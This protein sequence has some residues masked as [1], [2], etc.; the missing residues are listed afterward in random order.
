M[1]L[2]WALALCAASSPSAEP[3]E[4]STSAEAAPAPRV[5]FAPLHSDL[6][7]PFAHV[8]RRTTTPATAPPN[9]LKDP[10]KDVRPRGSGSA[11]VKS[12]A[13]LV[14]PFATRNVQA[15]LQASA[16]KNPFAPKEPATSEAA[17][18][19]VSPTPAPVETPIQRPKRARAATTSTPTPTILPPTQ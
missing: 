5:P 3:V 13:P 9:D 15:E 12:T 16:L 4:A 1:F 18:T 14:D 8:P 11:A 7:D 2:A 19:E 17:S 10:F 6:R